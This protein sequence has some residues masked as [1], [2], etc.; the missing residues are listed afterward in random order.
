MADRLLALLDADDTGAI[1]D[2]TQALLDAGRGDILDLAIRKIGQRYGDDAAEELE[3][4]LLAAAEGARMGPS[5]WAE[6]VTLP[7]ALPPNSMPDAAAMG[8]SLVAAG[9]LAETVEVRFLP[10]WRSPDAVEA[11]SPIALR[12]VLLDL[13]AGEEP[14]DLPPGDTDD[15]ARRGFG[16]LLGL[17]LDWAIPSWETITADG[18]P[19]APDEEDEGT[20]PEQAR[21]A[22]LFDGWRGAVF[23]ASGGGVPLALVP[24]SEVGVG[25]RR[26]PRRGQRPCRRPRGD[27]RI[28]HHGA[29][30]G[31]RRGR[32]LPAG[33]DRRYA[34]A[35]DLQRERPLPRQPDAA[36]GA[37]AGPGRGDAAADPEL[38]A[39]RQGRAGRRARR[40][41]I[42]A[43]P[44][45]ARSPS[46]RSA[47]ITVVVR[48]GR[49]QVRR[50]LPAGSC[51]RVRPPGRTRS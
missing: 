22:A 45:P 13:L 19:D 41:L 4:N 43:R 20:T 9:L 2:L 34:G 38:R 46:T 12:R 32:G 30:R 1:D 14:R 33:G 28:R 35:G 49:D 26:V 10:G 29:E 48:S 7:V 47:A 11:L 23:E 18:P 21:R 40:A 25:D 44:R 50:P 42:S 51:S 31:R 36:R 5:G 16:L 3:A 37:A 27:P 6:L 8:A 17:Q 15:L 39:D 24:P